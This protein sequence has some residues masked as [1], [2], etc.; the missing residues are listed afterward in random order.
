MQNSEN[1]CEGA[2]REEKEKESYSIAKKDLA[3]DHSFM[4]SAKQSK[5]QTTP[6]SSFLSIGDQ[7]WPEPS[8]LLEVPNLSSIPPSWKI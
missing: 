6:P 4:T 3:R 8:L 5:I 1:N 2:E 7:V